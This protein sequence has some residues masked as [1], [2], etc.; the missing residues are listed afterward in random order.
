MGICHSVEYIYDIEID[1]L[2][3][4]ILIKPY[5]YIKLK[6]KKE[7]KFKNNIY[8]IYLNEYHFKNDL[9]K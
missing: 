6:N 5:K 8:W 9:R 1:D 4:L 3:P 2:K 7:Y